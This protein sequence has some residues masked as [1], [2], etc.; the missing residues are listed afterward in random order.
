MKPDDTRKDKIRALALEGR[1][2]TEIGKTLGLPESTVRYYTVKLLAEGAIP[3][4]ALRK[5]NTYAT[6]EQ[7]RRIAQKY[8]MSYGVRYGNLSDLVGSLLPKQV[9]W[10]LAQVPVDGSLI[11]VLRGVVNDAYAE[12]IEQRQ[13][14][15]APSRAGPHAKD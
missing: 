10:L 11:D 5:K 9:D 6:R 7:R 4:A 14:P 2:T 13:N 15:P 12:E 3:P 8:R 1:A